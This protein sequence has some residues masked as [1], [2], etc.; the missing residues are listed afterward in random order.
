MSKGPWKPALVPYDQRSSGSRASGSGSSSAYMPWGAAGWNAAGQGSSSTGSYMPWGPV[1]WNTGG[2]SSSSTGYYTPWGDSGWNVGMYVAVPPESNMSWGSAGWNT[3]GQASGSMGS[4][5]S[6]RS[7]IWGNGGQGSNST[8]PQKRVS[9]DSASRTPASTAYGQIPSVREYGHMA[10]AAGE[11]ETTIEEESVAQ[12]TVDVIMTTAPPV[13]G[14]TLYPDP[15]GMKSR[16]YAITKDRPYPNLE[17]VEKVGWSVDWKA[18]ASKENRRWEER[19]VF[20]ERTKYRNPDEYPWGKYF[21]KMDDLK[22]LTPFRQGDKCSLA[23]WQIGA[24]SYLRDH[25]YRKHT[26]CTDNLRYWCYVCLKGP[27]RDGDLARCAAC[28]KV[29]MCMEHRIF[30]D[31]MHNFGDKRITI[32]CRH[33]L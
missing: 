23:R 3:G 14:G 19:R 4:Y 25:C 1:G 20:C 6:Q 24:Y 27:T 10:P 29:F 30:P 18:L 21:A 12:E 2:Q 11:G 32:C 8:K 22:H 17:K 26:Q 9:M 7:E 13:P 15:V 31:C 28:D 16:P 5:M 33:S